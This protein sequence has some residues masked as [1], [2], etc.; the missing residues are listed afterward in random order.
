[1]VVLRVLLLLSFFNLFTFIPS[2][3]ADIVIEESFDAIG[4]S[5]RVDVGYVVGNSKNKLAAW[6]YNGKLFLASTAKLR[7]RNLP[8]FKVCGTALGDISTYYELRLRAN[9][10]AYHITCHTNPRTD[11]IEIFDSSR[12]NRVY[13]VKKR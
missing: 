9:L 1:M 12:K 10:L 13:Q 7:H 5:G 8:G 3:T 2:A 4:F 6:Y 11:F